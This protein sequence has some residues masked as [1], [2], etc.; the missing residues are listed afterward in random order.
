MSVLFWAV[1]ALM[2][3]ERIWKEALVIRFFQRPLPPLPKPPALVSILQPVISGDPQ[4]AEVLEGT[5]RARCSYNR[6][7]LWLGD[8][9]DPACQQTCA[10]I[11]ARYP[12][13]AIHYVAL[14]PPPQGFNPKM[15]KLMMCAPM[16]RGTVVCVLDDDTVIPDDGLERCLPYL[17]QPGVG[18][19]FGLPYYVSF[20][21]LW[22]SMTAMFVDSNSLLTYVPYTSVT[23]P[24]TINGMFYA[25]KRSTL[26][27]VGGFVGL[28]PYLAD[29]FAVAYRFREH[30]YRLAQTPLLHPIRTQVR[31]GAHYLRL[32]RRWCIAPRES[33][34]R[35]ITP[36]EQA[37]FYALGLVPALFPLLAL[38]ALLL[39]PS[40]WT[41]GYALLYFSLSFA[42]FAYNNAR[43]LH[44][45]APWRYAWLVPVMQLVFPLQALAALLAPQHVNWRGNVMQIERGGTFRYVHRR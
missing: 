12:D 7:F 21:N 32:L 25:M 14:P 38:A 8:E 36:R 6:E 19:A 1:G 4:L 39:R 9:N 26:A 42:I 33:I 27:R 40:A 41:L 2:L 23:P 29:D 22:S 43:Y 34:M 16:A 44:G 45:A 31:D 18:L 13:H 20:T 28:E 10:A 37:I 24:F 15:F 3:A 30:G 35:Y 5:L 17:D 11:I